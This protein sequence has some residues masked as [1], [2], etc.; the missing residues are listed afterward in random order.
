MRLIISRSAVRLRAPPLFLP[1]LTAESRRLASRLAVWVEFVRVLSVFAARD[2]TRGAVG[3]CAKWRLR[4]SVAAL[5]SL[6]LTML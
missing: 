6:S 3:C 1:D 2:A 5:K 4:R